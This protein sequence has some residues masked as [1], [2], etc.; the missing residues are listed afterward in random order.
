[1]SALTGTN[2]WSGLKRWGNS[3]ILVPNVNKA[4]FFESG[5]PEKLGRE[6]GT[7][8]LGTSIS[9]KTGARGKF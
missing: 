2:V 7:P 8:L 6:C 5:V 1:M 4:R 9:Q 3:K